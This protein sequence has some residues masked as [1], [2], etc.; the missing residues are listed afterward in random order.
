M[1]YGMFT[2]TGNYD[3]AKVVFEAIEALRK[4]GKKHPEVA[5]TAVRDQICAAIH[6]ARLS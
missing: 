2:A 4:V 5:D 6:K 3:V 1:T